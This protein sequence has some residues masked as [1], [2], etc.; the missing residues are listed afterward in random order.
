[1]L[2]LAVTLCV[3]GVI[4]LVVLPWAAGRPKMAAHLQWLDNEGIDPS[5]MYYTELEMM[6]PILDRLALE[7]RERS[8]N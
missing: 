7:K 1:M 3:I 4:W 8:A 5:A 2:R 6:E